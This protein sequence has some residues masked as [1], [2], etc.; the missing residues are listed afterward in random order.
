MNQF[1]ND[2]LSSPTNGKELTIICKQFSSTVETCC[3]YS[4]NSCGL[5]ISRLE[6]DNRGQGI[7]LPILF[8]INSGFMSQMYKPWEE[9][10]EKEQEH[11]FFLFIHCNLSSFPPMAKQI[12]VKANI[13]FW[14]ASINVQETGLD[15][16][17]DLL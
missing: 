17:F 4:C 13:R 2:E 15:D 5:T 9:Q 3:H 7:L 1:P 16:S 6:K 11:I 14:V 10:K 8:N 12:C